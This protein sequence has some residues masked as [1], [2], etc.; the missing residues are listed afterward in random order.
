MAKAL[1]QVNQHTEAL[2]IHERTAA[3]L[4]AKL[5][6]DDHETLLSMNYLGICLHKLGRLSES[7]AS[8]KEILRRRHTHFPPE[9]PDTLRTMNNLASVFLS[10]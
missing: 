3:T 5:G 2:P 9:F 1:D 6:P 8:F 10:Q 7:R 4:R